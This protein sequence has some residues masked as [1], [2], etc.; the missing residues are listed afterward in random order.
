MKSGPTLAEATRWPRFRSAA[1]TPVAMVVLPTPEWV[2]ATTNRG[3]MGEL[4]GGGSGAV[5]GESELD[6]LLRLDALVERMFDLAHLGHRVCHLDELGRRI[7]PGDDHV[8]LRRPSH[9][10][11]DHLIH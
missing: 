2:P 11:F 5:L 1:M 6:S 7:P 8:G 3:G 4:I 9:H 10:R